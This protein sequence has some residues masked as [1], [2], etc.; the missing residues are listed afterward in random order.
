[1]VDHL[2]HNNLAKVPQPVIMQSSHERN[3]EIDLIK[4][5]LV[6]IMFVYHS[7]S[8]SK[9]AE[10]AFLRE[11]LEF[12][13][14]AFLTVSGF[15]CGRQY[16]PRIETSSAATVKKRL[17]KRGSKLIIIVLAVNLAILLLR[18]LYQQE[19]K[20]LHIDWSADNLIELLSESHALVYHILYFIG[21]FLLTV[22]LVIQSSTRMLFSL[23]F[24][25]LGVLI[26]TNLFRHV[27]YGYIGILGWTL[28]CDRKTQ[29]QLL[30]KKLPP[31][32]LPLLVLLIAEFLF[33]AP[34]SRTIS[35][36]MAAIMLE[37]VLWFFAMVYLGKMLHSVAE[38]DRWI[39]LLG[40]YTLFAYMF[41]VFVVVAAYSAI[42]KLGLNGWICYSVLL[43][44]VTITTFASVWAL[45]QARRNK[46]VNKMYM[47]FFG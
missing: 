6:M 46:T 15:L 2:L 37:M 9:I 26:P 14:Y 36:K 30:A 12:L 7:A 20:F 40:R 13:H 16:F 34:L 29:F 27:A 33:F 41:H 35:P 5:S 47:L 23:G 4:G 21:V 18:V 31:F 28:Y 32:A 10:V 43:F 17:L 25:L 1:M 38:L 42:A 44:I 45:D 24:V 19:A 3:I 22:L 11:K 8:G 39:L